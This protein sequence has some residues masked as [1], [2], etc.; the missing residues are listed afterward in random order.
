[1]E[2]GKAGQAS[3]SSGGDTTD[4]LGATARRPRWALGGRGH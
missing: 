2:E 3:M 4:R 1:M